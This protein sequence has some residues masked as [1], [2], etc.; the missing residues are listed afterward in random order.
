M[1]IR[2][3]TASDRERRRLAR[4][5]RALARAEQEDFHRGGA[6]VL[7]PIS[8]RLDLLERIV[9]LLEDKERD[10]ESEGLSDLARFVD[11]THPVRDYGQ[12]ARERNERIAAI[13]AELGGEA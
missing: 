7:G 1:G 10:I 5:T 11:E 9:R 4:E 2:S 3:T 6:L 13:L 8:E 12:S